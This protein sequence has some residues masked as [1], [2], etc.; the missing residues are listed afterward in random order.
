LALPRLYLSLQSFGEFAQRFFSGYSLSGILEMGF[1]SPF[2]SHVSWMISNISLK[3]IIDGV[4]YWDGEVFWGA[5][6]L[7]SLLLP[8]FF[9]LVP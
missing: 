4:P 3:V 6:L 9:I 2:F 5:V 1:D 8:A 7:L